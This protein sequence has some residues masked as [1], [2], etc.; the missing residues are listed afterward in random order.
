MIHSTWSGYFRFNRG[1]QSCT[2]PLHLS[3]EI[4]PSTIF[5]ATVVP[6]VAYLI[7][8]RMILKPFTRSEEER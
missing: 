1:S 3:Q 7:F 2:I 4:L 6:V 5:Y 8:D